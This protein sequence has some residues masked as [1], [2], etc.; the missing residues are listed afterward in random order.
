VQV[1]QDVKRVL[2]ED[3]QHG[4]SRQATLRKKAPSW[5]L[6]KKDTLMFKYR[7]RLATQFE[8]KVK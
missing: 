7:F 4:K 3:E 2:S 8:Q 6:T 5:L 1:A